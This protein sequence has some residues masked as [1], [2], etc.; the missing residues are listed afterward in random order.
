MAKFLD[1]KERVIDF[2]LTP[3]GKHRLAIGQLKPSFYSFFD[4]GII[5]DSEYAG[6]S[7][8]QNNIHERVKN[9][10]QFIEGILLFEEVE[11]TIPPGATPR[12]LGGDV[13][14]GADG[15][16]SGPLSTAAVRSD[17]E[18]L[19]TEELG[20]GSKLSELPSYLVDALTSALISGGTYGD[21]IGSVSLFD[22]DIVPQRYVP[23]PDT[24]SYESAIGD[25]KFEGDNT[26]AAPAWKLVTCQGEIT[27]IQEKDTSHYNLSSASFDR[28]QQ[29]F[30]IPQVELKSYYTKQISKPT[31]FLVDVETIPGFVSETDTFGDGNTIKL[32]RDDVVIYAEEMNTELLTENFD[33]EVFEMI[34]DAGVST[35]STAD[36][37]ITSSPDVGDTIT[38]NDGATTTTFKFVSNTEAG[39]LAAE[40]DFADS[41]IISVVRSSGYRLDG[42]GSNRKGTIFNLISAIRGDNGSTDQG[43]PTDYDKGTNADGDIVGSFPRCNKSIFPEGCHV[44]GH[45]LNVT[46]TKALIESLTTHAFGG[47]TNPFDIRI[48]NDN[49]GV[50]FSGNPNLPITT[51]AASSRIDPTGFSG[52]YSTKGTTLKRKYFKNENPQIVDGLMLS[53][54]PSSMPTPELTSESVDYYFSI[55]TDNKVN[56]KIACSC[57]NTFNKNSYYIDIDF[58]CVEEELNKIYYDIYGSATTPEICDSMSSDNIQTS[59]VD[60]VDPTEDIC[61]DN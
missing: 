41:G 28:E 36:I 21:K 27:D 48:T 14:S 53:A 57:A 9:K 1:K 50:G 24:L 30:N 54:N 59:I 22:I 12:F 18:S 19:L 35:K 23:K 55:L 25:A 16:S 7:E 10:T 52:G 56:G 13:F 2:Q 34:E 17:V 45:G 4:T 37:K 32:I 42:V 6:F 46:I 60:L 44:G 5:Y 58:D 20:D 39:K 61:E 31:P 38:I 11:N 15:G 51:T 49:V 26:Q 40:S 3:Y 8:A 47:T 43:Y 33:V 29:E